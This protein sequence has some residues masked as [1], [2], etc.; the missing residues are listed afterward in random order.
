ML[1]RKMARSYSRYRSICEK[2]IIDDKDPKKAGFGADAVPG[3]N[4]LLS[5]VLL[6]EVVALDILPE[7]LGHLGWGYL[8]SFLPSEYGGEMLV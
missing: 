1:P 2:T 7:S 5:G 6:A 3:E 8:L 4:V